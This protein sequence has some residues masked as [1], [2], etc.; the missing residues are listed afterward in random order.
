MEQKN[1]S[2]AI[3][4][5]EKKGDNEKAPDYRGSANYNGEPFEIALWLKTSDKGTKYFSVAISEPY[6]KPEAEVPKSQKPKPSAEPM[7]EDDLPF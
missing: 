5:N 4:K 6:K 1:N 3:F 7:P 2:G